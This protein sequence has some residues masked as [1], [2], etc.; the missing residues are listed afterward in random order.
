MGAFHQAGLPLIVIGADWDQL[1][2]LGAEASNIAN[3]QLPAHYRRALAVIH[4]HLQAITDHG[5]LNN[6][7]FDVLAYAVPMIT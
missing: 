2:L 7:L 6:L 1:G 3:Q 4:D 5:H